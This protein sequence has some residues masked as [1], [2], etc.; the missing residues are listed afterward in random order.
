M[1][2]AHP[3]T[4]LSCMIVF[5]CAPHRQLNPLSHERTPHTSPAAPITQRPEICL[6][7]VR[8]EL[9]K[10]ETDAIRGQQYDFSNEASVIVDRHGVRWDAKKTNASPYLLFG[11]PEAAVQLDEHHFAWL[12]EHGQSILTPSPL[13][14]PL[15]VTLPPKLGAGEEVARVLRTKKYVFLFGT[16]QSILRS[17]NGGQSWQALNLEIPRFAQFRSVGRTLD[18]TWQLHYFPMWYLKS[19]DEGGTWNRIAT[20]TES[21]E[22]YQSWPPPHENDSASEYFDDSPIGGRHV[23]IVGDNLLHFQVNE[24]RQI[25]VTTGPMQGPFERQL[26]EMAASEEVWHVTVGGDNNRSFIAVLT[27]TGEQYQLVGFRRE[28]PG[29]RYVRVPQ[30]ITDADGPPNQVLTDSN[31]AYVFWSNSATVGQ[32]LWF[33]SVS[34]P[35]RKVGLASSI[36]NIAFD[37]QHHTIWALDERGQLMRQ[38]VGA[39][40]RKWKPTLVHNWL[41][42]LTPP[43][44]GE[45][46][47]RV[48]VSISAVTFDQDGTLRCVVR[49]GEQREQFL[50]RVRPN[51]GL[52]PILKLPFDLP[53]Y[54]DRVVYPNS[55]NLVSNVALAGKR[56]Y[57]SLGWETADGG[58]HWSRVDAFTD[59]HRVQ[60]I[61]SGC[62]VDH[63]HRIGWALPD[64]YAAGLSA[65]P[66]A[67]GMAHNSGHV[68]QYACVQAAPPIALS[69]AANCLPDR[70]DKVSWATLTASTGGQIS[71]LLH[72]PDGKIDSVGLLEANGKPVDFNTNLGCDRLGAFA[73]RDL[74]RASGPKAQ[75][76]RPRSPQEP[77]ANISFVRFSDR[78][79]HHV[80][81]S[82][83]QLT[84]WGGS[85]LLLGATAS[86]ME[87]S[88]LL[89]TDRFSSSRG[90]YDKWLLISDNN[91]VTAIDKPPTWQR[92]ISALQVDNDLWVLSKPSETGLES[93][94]PLI[95]AHYDGHRWTEALFDVPR[96]SSLQLDQGRPILETAQ[97]ATRLEPSAPADTSAPAY[98]MRSLGYFTL[99]NLSE[100]LPNLHPWN[101]AADQ[102]SRMC[103]G[104]FDRP[105]TLASPTA[106]IGVRAQT[107]YGEVAFSQTARRI[108]WVSD[109]AGCTDVVMAGSNIPANDPGPSLPRFFSGV[110]LFPNDPSHAWYFD[111]ANFAMAS[112]IGLRGQVTALHQ[113][114]NCR[115]IDKVR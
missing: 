92:V 97:L 64:G 69:A 102:Q 89:A 76:L 34:K 4:S 80:N 37:S 3:L 103:D 62:L 35:P 101:T 40:T 36:A 13:G 56:G 71:A 100:P 94:A 20:P 93:D 22:T 19:S 114:L 53:I 104:A 16:H 12:D 55:G 60:C 82:C 33:W 91:Q 47:S 77:C 88:L 68:I 18:D 41:A 50:V 32:T 49:V 84:S 38:L 29:K 2:L 63:A 14:P 52:L 8:W 95:T 28:G 24:I 86:V 106:S 42:R 54:D 9:P 110:L 111:S 66:L 58:E 44:S 108:R 15:A 83:A 85:S 72:L 78:T 1:R 61:S 25:E 48:S 45:H 57:T 96:S 51:G 79:Q 67:D 99:D 75:R 81:L 30:T 109:T 7:C 21:I 11:R 6:H 31:G 46:G 27:R 107:P 105:A 90:Q 87:R 26:V 115:R 74:E 5:G 73:I 10:P 70:S 98:A 113:P 17:D 112:A 39:D 43:I 23:A 65:T 59:A